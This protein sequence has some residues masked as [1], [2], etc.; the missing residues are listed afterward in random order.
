MIG[1]LDLIPSMMIIYSEKGAG[2]A[3][4]ISRNHE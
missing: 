2:G 3:R 1:E 4:E